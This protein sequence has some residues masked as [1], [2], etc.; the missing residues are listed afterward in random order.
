M[1]GDCVC[2][3]PAGRVEVYA[4]G[5]FCAACEHFHLHRCKGRTSFGTRCTRASLPPHSTHET[6]PISFMIRWLPDAK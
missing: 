4:N 6:L 5:Y 3:C 1:A 2:E